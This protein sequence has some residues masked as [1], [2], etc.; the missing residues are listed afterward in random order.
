L[1]KKRRRRR[2][3]RRGEEKEG[4][5]RSGGGEVEERGRG[6]RR[7]RRR[8]THLS[9][10]YHIPKLYTFSCKGQIPTYMHPSKTYFKRPHSSNKL[11][12]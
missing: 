11:N 1:N 4:R 6:R 3:G 5:R 2:K 12:L 7:R 10:N 8:T 9:I